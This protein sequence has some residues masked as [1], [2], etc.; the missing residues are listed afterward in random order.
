[1]ELYFDAPQVFILYQ[2]SSSS[3]SSL[4]KKLEVEEADDD[5]DVNTDINA[6]ANDNDNYD[7]KADTTNNTDADAD[8]K[9]ED[10]ANENVLIVAS[11]VDCMKIVPGMQDQKITFHAVT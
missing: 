11:I 3:S 5:A 2:L 10:V 4:V 1:M 9:I 7:V 8:D 6:N